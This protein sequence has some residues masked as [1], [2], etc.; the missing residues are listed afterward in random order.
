MKGQLLTKTPSMS[1]AI[2]MSQHFDRSADVSTRADLRL[3]LGVLGTPLAPVAVSDTECIPFLSVKSLPMVN[4]AFLSDRVLEFHALSASFFS[5]ARMV[6]W[7]VQETSSAQYIV[8]QYVC[9]TGVAR[10]SNVRNSYAMGRVKMIA[11]EF[12]TASEVMKARNVSKA[13]TSGFFVMWQMAPNMWNV[14][15]AVGGSKVH[16]GSNGKLVWRHTP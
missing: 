16:A 6:I 12:E 2:S 3:L 7:H 15:M 1:R 9:A 5:Q 11:T 13:S 14:E 4:L 10:L 8:Q